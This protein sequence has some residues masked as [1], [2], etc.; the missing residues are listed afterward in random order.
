MV[1]D[2]IIIGGSFSGLAASL[3][4]ARARR[5]VLVLDSGLPRN[6]FAVHSHGV[7][8]QDGRAGSDILADAAAQLKAYPSAQIYRCKATA[9]SREDGEL[10][11]EVDGGARWFTGRRVLLA[12]GVRDELPPIPGLRER[13]GVTVMHCPYCHG[14][15]LDGG[16]IGV[17]GVSPLSV[18]QA[19]LVSDWGDVTFFTDGK[20]NPDAEEREMLAR[21]KV[22]IEAMGVAAIEGD[23]DAALDVRLLDGRRVT[24]RGLFVGSRVEVASTLAEGLGCGIEETP[25]GHIISTG[26]DKQTSVP[27]VYAAGDTGQMMQSITMAMSDGVFAGINM[28]RSLIWEE[29]HGEYVAA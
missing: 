19:L 23:T 6:R 22:K 4:L 15:E 16:A 21:R 28:H 20:L 5:K 13:W 17:L 14:Y 27:G 3:Q 12:T 9:V 18:H 25:Q 1:Y 29:A 11:V 2:A 7:L 26:P 24:L 10:V 8:A